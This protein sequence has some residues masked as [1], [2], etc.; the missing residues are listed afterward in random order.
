MGEK[1]TRERERYIENASD[2]AIFRNIRSW[3]FRD[4][5]VRDV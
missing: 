1:K 5:S 2:R 3:C 4:N